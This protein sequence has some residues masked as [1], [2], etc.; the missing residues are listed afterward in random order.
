MRIPTHTHTH[1]FYHTRG[2]TS[3][4][5]S[6][7]FCLP[8]R[9]LALAFQIKVRA[10]ARNCLQLSLTNKHAP[11]WCGG[12]GANT[13]KT[14]RAS[15]L[16]GAKY[17][18]CIRHY[19]AQREIGEVGFGQHCARTQKQG[20]GPRKERGGRLGGRGVVGRSKC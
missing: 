7:R 17:S 13:R 15:R 4:Q 2:G 5:A 10:P 9:L 1:T 6:S 14:T 16:C 19:F 8:A 12:D 18:L 11:S 3:N 20:E